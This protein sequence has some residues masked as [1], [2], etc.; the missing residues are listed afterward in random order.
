MYGAQQLSTSH[1]RPIE[2]MQPDIVQHPEARDR[3]L[4]E[5]RIGSQIISD[6]VVQVVAPGIEPGTGQPWLVMELL[7]GEDIERLVKRVV[8]AVEAVGV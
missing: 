8:S 4:L 2:V 7:D 1:L 5:A 6:H 3:F